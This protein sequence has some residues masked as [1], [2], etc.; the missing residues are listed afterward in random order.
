MLGC[1]ETMAGGVSWVEQEVLNHRLGGW[2]CFVDLDFWTW[3]G[4]CL[5]DAAEQLDLTGIGSVRGLRWL[6]AAYRLSIKST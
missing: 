1:D 3:A 5:D 2:L 6:S 4:L